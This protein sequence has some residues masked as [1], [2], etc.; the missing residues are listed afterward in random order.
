MDILVRS[1]STK[2]TR[3]SQ[4]ILVFVCCDNI[5][6]RYVSQQ[7]MEMLELATAVATMLLSQP[8][9]LLLML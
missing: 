9:L 5:P 8:K 1:L 2:T 3:A 4:S 7:R 6:K